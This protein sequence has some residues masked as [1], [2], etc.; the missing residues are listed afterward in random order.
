MWTFKKELFKTTSLDTTVL[1]GGS[2]S[3]S[4]NK[5]I[6]ELELEAGLGLG[7]MGIVVNSK[8]LPDRFQLY[9]D[10]VLVAD[11]K[12]IGDILIPGP[13][14]GINGQ[15]MIGDY[16]LQVYQYDGSGFNA[17]S[18]TRTITVTQDD[19]ANNNTEAICGYT[20]LFFEKE[21]STP[22]KVK[23]VITGL[24]ESTIWDL[25]EFV[26]PFTSTGNG[27]YSIYY[28]FLNEAN[29]ALKNNPSSRALSKKLYFSDDP[30]NIG[31]TKFYLD[32]R[33]E[34]FDFS[35]LKWN[36]TNRFI[37]NTFLWYELDQYGN[38]LSQGPI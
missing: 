14:V 9:H 2:V 29:K 31:T 23:L 21:T 30:L 22:T 28:G 5:G 33:T 10:D 36:S 32:E 6:Y 1:C 24:S 27:A 16:D 18:E 35:L 3:A 7:T 11:T 15:V 38:I 8:N 26:C 34:E 37:N 20:T 13:P 17:T 12:Y 25:L 19:I 4:G